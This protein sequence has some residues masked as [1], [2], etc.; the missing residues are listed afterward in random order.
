MK[1]STLL[2]RNSP[3]HRFFEFFVPIAAL[4]ILLIYS[5]ARFFIIPYVGFQFYGST[6]EVIEIDVDQSAAPFLEVGDILVAVNGES[7][8]DIQESQKENP[9]ARVQPGETVSLDVQGA[10]GPK[11]VEWKTSGFNMPEF[12]TRL[13][14]RLAMPFGWPGLPPCF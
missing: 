3:T 10:E 2:D 12:W 5:Y 11:H 8:A 7:W 1:N 6:G 4:G 13:P 9:L 14:G